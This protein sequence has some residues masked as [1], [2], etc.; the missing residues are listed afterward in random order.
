M[1]TTRKHPAATR[2][3]GTRTLCLLM[4]LVMALSLVQVSVFA[5]GTPPQVMSGNYVLNTDGTISTDGSGNAVTAAPASTQD[6]YTLTKTAAANSSK[7]ENWFDVAVQVGTAQTITTSDA[8]VVLVIDTSGSMADCA[9]CGRSN[10]HSDSC[11]YSGSVNPEQSRMAA[12]INEAKAFVQNLK[13]SN[14][15]GKVYVS[16]VR[17]SGYSQ[18]DASLVTNWT[19][20]S[21]DAGA[22]A[23]KDSINS[24][25]LQASGGTNMEAGLMMARNLLNVTAASIGGGSVNI[26]ALANKYTVLLTDG[27]PTARCNNDHTGLDA[28]YDYNED[29][30][31]Q[32]TSQAER[33]EAAAM[34]TQVKAL[35]KLYTI[36]YGVS[37]D[38]L[39]TTS[40]DPC[41][42]CGKPKSEHYL[43][44]GMSGHA[45]YYCGPGYGYNEYSPTTT[46]VTVG[47]YLRDSIATA[48]TSDV[49]YAFNTDNLTALH[50]AFADI[51]NSASSGS[52]GGGTQVIDPMGAEVV[53]DQDSVSV[54]G[55]TAAKT[56]TALTWTLDPA[57]ASTSTTGGVTTYT[58]TMTY[59]VRLATEKQGFAQG[60]Y[61][62]TNGYTYLSVPQTVGSP[63]Q[64]AFTV[65]A[66]RGFTGSLGFTKTDVAGTALPG[67][68]FKLASTTQGISWSQNVQS[69]ANGEVSFTSIPS[70]CAFTLTETEA[71]ANY[72]KDNT[73]YTL[74]VA[75]GQLSWTGSGSPL[76]TVGSTGNAFANTATQQYTTLDISKTW[77]APAGTALP[78]SIEVTLQRDGSDY[79]VIT[80]S[81]T[82]ASWK[83]NHA[84]ADDHVTVT[85]GADDWTCAV[86]VPLNKNGLLSSTYSYTVQEAN[87]APETWASSTS[88]LAITNSYM[89][90][91]SVSVTKD[92]VSG[93]AAWPDGGITVKL[94]KDSIDTG[95]TL[96][97]TENVPT[98]IFTDLPTV[99]NGKVA[100]YT[101]AEVVNDASGAAMF[102][103]V[104]I[105]GSA[106]AGYTITNAVN[107]ED[108]TISGSKTWN[109][110]SN[111]YG[112]RP[113]SVTVGLYNGDTLKATQTVTADASGNWSYSFSEDS[114]SNNLP[115]YEF[116]YDGTGK[117]TGVSVISYTVREM[118]GSTALADGAVAGGYAVT[119]ND[120][121]HG[122]VNTLTGTV[123]VSVSKNW[124]DVAGAN[125]T[126]GKDVTV[127]L[128]QNGA[129][130]GDAKT[131]A[132]NGTATIW[133]GLPKYDATG[134][135]YSYTVGSENVSGEPAGYTIKS[136]TANADKTAYT[137]TNQLIDPNN[138]SISGTKT[139]AE[140]G[141]TTHPTATV[142]LF[143]RAAG[144]SEDWVNTNMTAEV[145]ADGTYSFTN[146]PVY[147]ERTTGGTTEMTA[148]EYRIFE[149]NGTTPVEEGGPIGAYVVSYGTVNQSGS[150]FTQNLTNTITGTTSVTVNK[151]WVDGVNSTNRNATFTLSRSA[152]GN[153]DTAFSATATQSDL[154]AGGSYTWSNL[155]KYDASGRLYT[156]TVG[157]TTNGYSPEISANQ[158]T[159]GAFVYNITNTLN[160][161]YTSITVTKN[162]VDGGN[163]ANR[164]ATIT[165]YLYR[166]DTRCASQTVTTVTNGN[167]Q[168]YTFG[169]DDNGAPLPLYNADRTAQYTYTIGE[170]AVTG[171]T[172]A[173]AAPNYDQSTHVITNAL[174]QQTVDVGVAKVWL[175]PTGTE[176]PDVTFTVSGAVNGEAAI[177]N[178]TALAPV[179]AT[180]GFSRAAG[181]VA[182]TT[183]TS[184]DKNWIYTFQGLPKYDDNGYEIAY[185]VS[186]GELAGYT[187]TKSKGYNT[188]TNTI[189]QAET[190]FTVTKEF[191]NMSGDGVNSAAPTAP[192]A[193][194]IQLMA[195]G[196]PVGTPVSMSISENTGYYTFSGLNAYD[197]NGQR[198]QYTAVE[199]VP[200][201]GDYRVLANGGTVGY[202]GNNY[203]VSYGQPGPSDG[204][205]IQT[206][207]NTY[208]LPSTFYYK[209]T[210]NYAQ[211]RNGVQVAAAS[212]STW[213]PKAAPGTYTE[214]PA[215]Y[216]TYTYPAAGGE[217]GKTVTHS[218]VAA[219]S[220]T[221]VDVVNPNDG[222]YEIVLNYVETLNSGAVVRHVYRTHDTYTGATTVDETVE[223]TSAYNSTDTSVGTWTI[224]KDTGEASFVPAVVNRTGYKFLAEAS[225]EEGGA[226][227]VGETVTYTLYYERTTDSTPVGPYI[228][229]EK[230]IPDPDV[231]LEPTPV[232]PVEPG[233]D[234]TDP[235]VPQAG[236]AEQTTGDELYLWIALATASGMSLAWLTISGKKRR[237]ENNK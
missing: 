60:T 166:N 91:T 202:G 217:G 55:G 81:R 188:I 208:Q 227:P 22:A 234:I 43:E 15:G 119:Y 194:H 25:N 13:D 183:G 145:G 80:L 154:S 44:Y 2:H 87:F 192:A 107:Q 94:L 99:A 133:S 49:T 138:A 226:V 127:Q 199:V 228:P 101:V 10:T 164:P 61:Y 17:F 104:G 118:N 42:I 201:D 224:N 69:D 112:T 223:M 115:K 214:D 37:G 38:T 1:K 41:T 181:T 200:T 85:K 159:N 96:T 39:Y 100:V 109:D 75:Y 123:D 51:A 106:A 32:A 58:Y 211:Y 31:G 169:T 195:G 97:L 140:P 78:G 56:A 111:A 93:I 173:Y 116:T 4:S 64:L 9:V 237:D 52:T 144:S 185:T 163:T 182:P 53:L 176:H 216:T 155:A 70:G 29:G 157:E 16:V 184:T 171:T 108:V 122:I 179:T 151:T 66:V 117:I 46:K 139:W 218:F 73:E 12:T 57:T 233:T 186:E 203:T 162:W 236:A 68:T 67:A 158:S 59:S 89:G 187:S 130:Y 62:P 168:T 126:T 175:D 47:D 143:K 54:T 92:W 220:N 33:N 102:Q 207:T 36:C 204:G 35:S 178:K 5:T 63:E 65:P 103:Q 48:A 27:Q 34:A 177:V 71:P 90:T 24:T 124:I 221:S 191:A 129:A 23:V 193:V 14:S 172:N 20:V 95:K 74:G 174:A 83:T 114:H 206:I 209:L 82:A 196:V 18:S 131:V 197:A 40:G 137:I 167:T 180:V 213:V 110:N 149:M 134:T 79:G 50:N 19:D 84:P 230:P 120:S 6:G 142:G 232:T 190:T 189:E 72:D 76:Q 28:I 136:V 135:A 152:D 45:H 235:D 77:I 88:G 219:G 170:A 98:R 229:P 113:T 26:S 161:A 141:G 231:P 215:A 121:T 147:E 132:G 225:Q 150:T 128:M 160:Q 210:R 222:S 146:L 165:L 30:N 212:V 8:A 11:T 153:A 148:L 21:T 105:T 3:F 205:S 7:G 86:T 125:H 156:Y 198:I